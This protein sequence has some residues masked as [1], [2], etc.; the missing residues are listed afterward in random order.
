MWH[1]LRLLLLVPFLREACDIHG[2]LR[3]ILCIIELIVVHGINQSLILSLVSLRSLCS[4][5]GWWQAVIGLLFSWLRRGNYLFQAF[6]LDRGSLL[7]LCW[8]SF[9]LLI[10]VV[11]LILGLIVFKLI[12]RKVSCFWLFEGFL[13]IRDWLWLTLI[14][15]GGACVHLLHHLHPYIHLLCGLRIHWRGT[16]LRIVLE[17]LVKLLH[18]YRHLWVLLR[19]CCWTIVWRDTLR[20]NFA[21][22]LL[23]TRACANVTQQFS[24]SFGLNAS[25]RAE[26]TILFTFNGLL[27]IILIILVSFF[28]SGFPAREQLASP[29][30]PKSPS[31]RWTILLVKI[32]ATIRLASL[33]ELL[34]ELSY[35]A[36]GDSNDY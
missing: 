28:R 1:H 33:I 5:N 30:A 13:L 25:L 17:H 11:W 34:F 35:I 32:D 18:D 16:R 3:I 12:A 4:W 2:I 19:I 36:Y 27:S 24:L 21:L 15:R 7:S 9:C 14:N 22:T 29:F 10:F 26:A 23:H 8:R 31:L 20:V 6:K